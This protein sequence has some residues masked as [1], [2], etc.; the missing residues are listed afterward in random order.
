MSTAI[1]RRLDALEQRAKQTGLNGVDETR[2]VSCLGDYAL[3]GTPIP[4]ECEAKIME[5]FNVS[6]LDAAADKYREIWKKLD[7]SV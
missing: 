7:A 5:I 3:H 1:K 2:A 6:S 4:E